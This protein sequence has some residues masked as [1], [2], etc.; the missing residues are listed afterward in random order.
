MR[1]TASVVPGSSLVIS[2][3]DLPPASCFPAPVLFSAV[4]A[5]FNGTQSAGRIS[6]SNCET[7]TSYVRARTDSECLKCFDVRKP[8][9]V[10]PWCAAGRIK[11]VRA[12]PGPARSDSI[13]TAASTHAEGQLITH[14]DRCAPVEH[15]IRRMFPGGRRTASGGLPA[16]RRMPADAPVCS[17]ARRDIAR[18][19]WPSNPCSALRRLHPMPEPSAG[20]ILVV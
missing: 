18:V 10:V 11:A 8:V 3:I 6:E 16:F 13:R 17:T 7:L 9:A 14:V 2:C 5:E 1:T 12:E 19:L 20:S 4:R 15:S